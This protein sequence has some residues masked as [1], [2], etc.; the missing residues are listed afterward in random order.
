VPIAARTVAALAR[1][2]PEAIALAVIVGVAAVLGFT[3]GETERIWL[4]FV[5][6]ACVSAASLPSARGRLLLGALAAQALLTEVLFD[7]IW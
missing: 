3:K 6:L 5:P 1:R 7:T 4:P 2:E